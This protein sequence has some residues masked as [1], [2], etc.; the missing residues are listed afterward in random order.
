MCSFERC[1]FRS[2]SFFIGLFI[3]LLLSFGGIMYPLEVNILSN[4]YFANIFSHSISCLFSQSLSFWS[5]C[6]INGG[7]KDVRG[8]DGVLGKDSYLNSGQALT[9]DVLPAAHG[10]CL[11]VFPPSFSAQALSRRFIHQIYSWQVLLP[12]LLILCYHPH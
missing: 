6:L 4:I 5:A 2:C 10:G 7:L 1:L 12:F 9:G 8:D 3:Y 11:A